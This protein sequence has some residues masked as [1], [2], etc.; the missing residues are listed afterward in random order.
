MWPIWLQTLVAINSESCQRSSPS[1]PVCA[2]P[3]EVAVLFDWNLSRHP[4]QGQVQVVYLGLLLCTGFDLEHPDLFYALFSLETNAV[5]D[6]KI[7]RSNWERLLDDKQG[8]E[9]RLELEVSIPSPTWPTVGPA[10]RFRKVLPQDYFAS[11]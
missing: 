1:F 4:F 2:P 9:L 11:K 7:E 6:W 8:F 3:S 5:K 10:T